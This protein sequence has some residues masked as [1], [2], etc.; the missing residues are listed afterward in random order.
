[1]NHHASVE[2]ASQS[3]LGRAIAK[4]KSTGVP[5][6]AHSSPVVDVA[7]DS[8]DD[9]QESDV[10]SKDDDQVESMEID[11]PVDSRR[12]AHRSMPECD[13]DSLKREREEQVGFVILTRDNNKPDAY[14]T[15]S[16]TRGPLP[17]SVVAIAYNERYGKNIASA[18]MEKRARQGRAVWMEKHTTYPSEII[19]SKQAKEPK[20]QHSKAVLAVLRPGGAHGNLVQNH[21]LPAT[22]R[23]QD[24]AG[25][26]YTHSSNRC[27]AGWLPPDH[28]RN[29][30]TL[31]N[32][33]DEAFSTLAGK[34][35]INVYNNQQILLGSI[36]A[37]CKDLRR[38][39]PVL[40]QLLDHNT[41]TF[42]QL[43]SWP[44]GLIEHYA[45]CISS[46]GPAVLPKRIL[47]DDVSVM[48]LYCFA[49]Q[50]QD[51]HVR[52]LILDHWRGLSQHKAEINLEL[53]DLNSLFIYTQDDDPAREF[54]AVTICVAGLAGRVLGMDGCHDALVAQV[55]KA[56]GGK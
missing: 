6:Q 28:I 31:N 56:I 13:K 18:A 52:G 20:V 21:N 42:M 3:A 16:E 24:G 38:S 44:L 10:G 25:T 2:A 46:E 14:G 23:L 19:Y 45:E 34:V 5:H 48:E 32:Y 26:R 4:L 43:H 37:Y 55:Q 1:M 51:D 8:A 9:Y 53:G 39:S 33:G 47:R 36:T 49:A 29:L 7:D 17:W 40:R 41:S 12:R 22:N 54:W 30:D 35:C 50:V 27:I 15:V 11:T